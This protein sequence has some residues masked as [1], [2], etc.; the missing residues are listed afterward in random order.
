MDNNTA[1]NVNEKLPLKVKLAYGLSGYSSFITWTIFSAY[2]LYFFTDIVG[3]SAAFAG[4]MIS[5]GTVWDAISDPLVGSISDGIKSEKGR[6][7]PLI[8]GVA[9]PF[10]LISILLF[11]NFG[12]SE[13]VSK[14]YFVV[15]IILY[16]TAQTVLDISCSALGSEM[17]IDYDERSTLATLKNFFAMVVVMAYS[18]FLLLTE[19]FGQF[20]EN[21]DYGWSCT[22]AV[23]M[24]VALVCIFI[25]WKTTKGYERHHDSTVDNKLDKATIKQII[26][27]KSVIIVMILFAVGVIGMT[28]SNSLMVYYFTYYVQLNSAQI[29]TA[30]LVLGIASCIASLIVDV[31]IKKTSKR[32]AW[33]ITLLESAIVVI[34]F[35][36]FIIGPGDLGKVCVFVALVSLGTA[37][38][39]QVPWAMIPD[40]VDVNELSTGK[41]TDGVIFGLI[42]FI[43]KCAGALSISICGVM[44]TVIGYSAEAVQT[45]ETLSSLKWLYVC[46]CGGIFGI[47]AIVGLI[48]PLSKKRHDDVI[49]AINDRKEGKDVD[50]AE[51]KDLLITKK[52]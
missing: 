46:G 5:L 14:V 22:L 28:C 38:V 50:L 15:V 23:Y 1:M 6:R 33:V 51:F 7:R 43:Q 48:Y 42:A 21:S 3:I 29:A 49:K 47:I 37:A 27:N 34:L 20:F 32:I 10:A 36:G 17:T 39:Y 8:I 30:F 45:A 9:I 44:L 31:I 52:G 16:Y 4:A 41:R 24:A 13:Q 40:T 18:P 2:G 35:V 12:F 26:K 19:F 25:I 11:T